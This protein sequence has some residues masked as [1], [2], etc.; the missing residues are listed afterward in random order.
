MSKK[1]PK[2][3]QSSNDKTIKKHLALI[4]LIV[5]IMVGVFHIADVFNNRCTESASRR[6]AQEFDTG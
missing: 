5:E 4:A 2:T 6:P 1:T 3:S